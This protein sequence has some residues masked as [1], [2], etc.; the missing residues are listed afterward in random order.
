[1]TYPLGPF[2]R[3][4]DLAAYSCDLLIFIAVEDFHFGSISMYSS[5]NVCGELI[6]GPPTDHKI[7]GC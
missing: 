6:P 2:L 5:L 4:C 3:V 7:Q 1:M